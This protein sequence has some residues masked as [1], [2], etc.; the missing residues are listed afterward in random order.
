MS[1]SPGIR[2]RCLVFSGLSTTPRITYPYGGFW[3]AGPTT[4]SG[5]QYLIP[6]T[7]SF[8][9]N[10]GDSFV[11]QYQN[12]AANAWNIVSGNI[13]VEKLPVMIGGK[14]FGISP[15]PLPKIRRASVRVKKGRMLSKKKGRA[16]R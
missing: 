3:T 6:G 16:G 15:H 5:T 10:T 9:L 1:S 7:A 12:T 13:V 14:M 4:M 11:I 8:I 2:V